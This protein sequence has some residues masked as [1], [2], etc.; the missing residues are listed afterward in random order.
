MQINVPEK[1]HPPEDG[2]EV[3]AETKI[4][5]SLLSKP[6]M[7]G[8]SPLKDLVEQHKLAPPQT[9]TPS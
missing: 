1:R 3:V 2:D 4:H 5:R 8:R 7:R 6:P 9:D